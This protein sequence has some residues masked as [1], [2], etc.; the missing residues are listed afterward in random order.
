MI[1]STSLPSTFRNWLQI[2]GTKKKKLTNSYDLTHATAGNKTFGGPTRPKGNPHDL[3]E[4]TSWANQRSCGFPRGN[5]TVG[6]NLTKSQ[7]GSSGG[8]KVSFPAGNPLRRFLWVLVGITFDNIGSVGLCHS[9]DLEP[10][11]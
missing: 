2:E 6:V 8:P 3:R 9:R 5:L 4:P 1:L 11:K 7:M 10:M